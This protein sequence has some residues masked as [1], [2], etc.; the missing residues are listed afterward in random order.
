LHVELLNFLVL[1]CTLLYLLQARGLVEP[2]S[3]CGRWIA[4][5]RE[6]AV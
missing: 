4:A 1:V 5:A 2:F 6:V 3:L